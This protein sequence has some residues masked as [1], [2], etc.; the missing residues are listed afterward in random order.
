MTVFS[1]LLPFTRVDVLV[2]VFGWVSLHG[3]AIKE[4]KKIMHPNVKRKILL[5]IISVG[6]FNW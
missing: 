1:T 6:L 5:L 2:M 3:T 4:D